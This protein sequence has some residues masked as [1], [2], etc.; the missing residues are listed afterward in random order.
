MVGPTFIL[1]EL[2]VLSN[3]AKLKKTN[4]FT[5]KQ[6]F[7]KED[8]EE[9][10]RFGCCRRTPENYSR[11]TPHSQRLRAQSAKCPQC[12]FNQGP[13]G[14]REER[15]HYANP[16][17]HQSFHFWMNNKFENLPN[18]GNCFPFI[19]NVILNLKMLAG[20]F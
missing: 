16:K 2:P 5:L 4:C 10:V 11:E 18:C 19:L 6:P 12:D 3:S 20:L 7:L 14:G 1:Q 13:T 8:K 15:Y 9:C 17:I